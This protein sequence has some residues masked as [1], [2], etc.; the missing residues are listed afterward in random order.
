MKDKLLPIFMGK[1]CEAWRLDKEGLFSN[2]KE[3]DYT[4]ARQIIWALANYRNISGMKIT[5]FM[6]SEGA[7][8]GYSVTNSTVSKGIRS[9]CRKM[10]QDADLRRIFNT[11]KDEKLF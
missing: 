8:F 5:N 3:R 2:P 11:I 6:N 9:F 4:S 7:E 10:E 1:V